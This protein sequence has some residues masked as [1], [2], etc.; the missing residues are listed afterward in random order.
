MQFS[1]GNRA[2][3]HFN[4]ILQEIRTEPP[5][6]QNTYTTISCVAHHR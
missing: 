5:P 4:I 1:E 2:T 3:A 6:P